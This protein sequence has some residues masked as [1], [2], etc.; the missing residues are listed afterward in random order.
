MAKYNNKQQATFI[1]IDNNE[2]EAIMEENI[3]FTIE[4]NL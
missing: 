4:K 1:S 3:T 2:L